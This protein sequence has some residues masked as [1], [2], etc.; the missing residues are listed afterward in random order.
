[1]AEEGM[2][3]SS[4]A[5]EGGT[6]SSVTEIGAVDVADAAEGEIIDTRAGTN[7]F[8]FSKKAFNS[9]RVWP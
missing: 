3:N 4:P 5:V 9:A 8:D 1:M 2:I 6:G 7:F